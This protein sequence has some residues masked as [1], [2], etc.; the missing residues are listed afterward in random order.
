MAEDEMDDRKPLENNL[1]EGK[2]T[3]R[4][5]EDEILKPYFTLKTREQFLRAIVAN[6]NK[7]K[8]INCLKNQ[9]FGMTVLMLN[10]DKVDTED[11]DK[12]SPKQSTLPAARGDNEFLAASTY[13]KP[14]HLLRGTE[15]KVDE[16]VKNN[17]LNNE[18][19]RNK[20]LLQSFYIMHCHLKKK[21]MET[22]KKQDEKQKEEK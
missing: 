22:K 4:K 20:F 16:F 12:L 10:L 14:H 17:I 5:E 13:Y 15:E 3:I 11:E 6:Y 21:E 2:Q 1:S 9:L 8:E 18:S 7:E 19:N